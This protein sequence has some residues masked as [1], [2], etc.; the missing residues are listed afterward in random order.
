VI[1]AFATVTEED[2]QSELRAVEK[3]QEYGPHKNI[4]A[5]LGVSSLSNSPYYAIDMELCC[6]NLEKYIMG[7]WKSEPTQLFSPQWPML[8][9]PNPFEWVEMMNIWQISDNIA[10]GLEFLHNLGLVHR[11]LKPANGMKDPSNFR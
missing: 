7:N 8:F 10:C 1:R 4:V 3:L 6:L 2:I 5:V 11:D 9:Q